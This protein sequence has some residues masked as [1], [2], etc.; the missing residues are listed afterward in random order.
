MSIIVHGIAVETLIQMFIDAGFEVDGLRTQDGAIEHPPVLECTRH[1]IR[2]IV[3]LIDDSSCQRQ[4]AHIHLCAE[5][6]ADGA[7]WDF[8]E[9]DPDSLPRHT[10]MIRLEREYT[11]D[12]GVTPEWI[13]RRIL[14]WEFELDEQRRAVLE[15]APEPSK[16]N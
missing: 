9:N 5:M 1:E 7:I 8:W 3:E 13:R 12:G 15:R 14:D 2:T 4:Y 16:G 6:P 11:C 10:P